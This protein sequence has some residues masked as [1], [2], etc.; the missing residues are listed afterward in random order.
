MQESADTYKQRQTSKRSFIPTVKRCL[1][2]AVQWGY[3]NANPI[4]NLEVPSAA[5][6]EGILTPPDY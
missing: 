6:R 1:K 4:E 5:W 2:W 3:V